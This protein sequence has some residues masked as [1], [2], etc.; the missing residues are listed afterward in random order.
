MRDLIKK[1]Q[2]RWVQAKAE[3]QSECESNAKFETASK[4]AVCSMF[5]GKEDLESLI[6]L[7]FS[8]QG[9]E[10]LTTYGFPD[11]A[12]FRKFKKYHPERYG[13]YI[14]CGEI[15]ISEPKKAFVV[16]NTIA[17]IKCE[18][19]AGNRIILMCGAK[20]TIIASGYSVVKIEKDK[21]SDVSYIKQDHAKILI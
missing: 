4:L 5:T 21:T 10:F 16:G 14:D 18:E 17:T 19:T 15:A 12:T 3:A 9:A 7:M 11:L 1:I 13:V 2:K 8:P 6:S 20:A